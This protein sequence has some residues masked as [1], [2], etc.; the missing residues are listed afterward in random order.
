LYS[1]VD[2]IVFPFESVLRS[3]LEWISIASF[4]ATVKQAG[5]IPSGAIGRVHDSVLTCVIENRLGGILGSGLIVY[6]GAS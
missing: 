1:I 5:S 2:N 4:G 6:F 3:M